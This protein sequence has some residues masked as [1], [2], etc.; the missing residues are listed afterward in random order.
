MFEYSKYYLGI[1]PKCTTDLV[2]CIKSELKISERDIVLILRKIR[3]NEEFK[4]LSHYFE[5]SERYTALIFS[6]NL[7]K[8][9][10]ALQSFIFWPETDA[11]SFMLPLAFIQKFKK[12]QS[13]IDCFEVYIEKPYQTQ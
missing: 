9:S 6:K 13:I 1:N 7:K 11:I 10:D 5:I 4:T 8:M 2:E 3:R 12:V